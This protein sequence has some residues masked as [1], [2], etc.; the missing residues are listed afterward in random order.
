MRGRPYPLP[1]AVLDMTLEGLRHRIALSYEAL[2]DS[3]APANL[4]KK[5]LDRMP[6]PVVP[7]HEH[8][9][10]RANA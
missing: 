6:A 1:Q 5:M 8:A 7:L 3:V 4:L 9:N 2:S 10:V